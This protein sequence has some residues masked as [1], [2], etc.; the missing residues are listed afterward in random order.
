M[1]LSP[2]KIPS[3][4]RHSLSSRQYRWIPG[5]ILLAVV[6]LAPLV[7]LIWQAAVFLDYDGQATWALLNER[8]A[9]LWV[10]SVAYGAAVALGGVILA[11]LAASALWQIPGRA[12]QRLRWFFLALAPLPSGLHALAWISAAGWLG[13]LANA[14]G[15]QQL[16]YRGWGW[17]IWVQ[18]MA[19]SPLAVGLALLGLQ[20]MPGELWDAARLVSSPW[21]AFW[22]I[23]IPQ[24]APYLLA[25]GG[26]LFL[27]SLTD[28]YLPATFQVNVYAFEIFTEFSA[29]HDPGR[30]FLISLP[31]CAVTLPVALVT[32]SQLQRILAASTPRQNAQP[33]FLWPAGWEL[34]QKSALFILVLQVGVP[35]IV[36]IL[37]AGPPLAFL[38]SV[39]AAG[40][41]LVITS[42][43][44]LL[45]A[46]A[47]LPLALLA[48]NFLETKGPMA[49]ISWVT[50]AVLMAL[51]ASLVGI[52]LIVIWN[53]PGWPV[54]GSL[55]MPLLALLVRWTPYAVIVL[56][57]QKRRI[58]PGLLEAEQ[59]FHTGWLKSWLYVRLP[60]LSPGLLASAFLIIALSMGELGATLLVLPPGMETL[61]IRLY[62]YLHYGAAQTVSA[63]SLLTALAGVALGMAMV[64]CFEILSPAR[65]P[66]P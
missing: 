36:L 15:I 17:L 27:L 43:I 62:N 2:S 65:R 55:L 16:S 51:P 57:A 18:I 64:W 32:G 19:L 20:R 6:F 60:L 34:L 38:Q 45:T 61:A 10:Q 12:Q 14:A 3:L 42:Q 31:L 9:R 56:A 40:R 53:H 4:P 13:A 7:G 41:E 54:Y 28:F 33:H 24:S 59:V 48:T 22:R 8:T 29:S 39:V 66:R 30:A 52:G 49:S 35:V 63:L 46:L 5:G 21:K 11:M 37:T 26:L 1:T 58:D 25:A 44:S 23:V 50:L 47:G